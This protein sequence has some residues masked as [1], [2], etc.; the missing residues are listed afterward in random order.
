MSCYGE[1]L[2]TMHPDGL[3]RMCGKC[4]RI[5]NSEVSYSKLKQMAQDGHNGAVEF[6]SLFEPYESLDAAKKVDAELV[7]RIL[8]ECR[9]KDVYFYYCKYLQ[10]NLCSRY[11]CRLD[12]CRQ[13]PSSLWQ[14][15][16]S[17]C[18]FE[19]WLFWRREEVKQKVRKYKEELIELKLL[20]LRTKD[21]ETLKRI[22]SVEHKIFKNIELYKKFGSENW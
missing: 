15:V 17:G 16:P 14:I 1:N 12:S 18:G 22:A 20:R 19:G 4:C 6:L 21:N 13:Y 10:D 7:G 9:G 5:V 8:A 11:E 2:L 3:C